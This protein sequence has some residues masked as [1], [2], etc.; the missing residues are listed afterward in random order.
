MSLWS[1]LQSGLRSV[2]ASTLSN[3]D[4]WLVRWLRGDDG[5]GSDSGVTVNAKTVLTYAPVWMGVNKIVGLV[6]QLPLCAYERTDER[7]NVKR[8]DHAGSYVLDY[9]NDLMDASV[10]RETITAHAILQGNGRA[11][12]ERD[13]RN[14]PLELIPLLP[15]RTKTILVNNKKWHVVTDPTTGEISK[16]PGADVL[17]ICGFGFDG[18]QGYSLVEMAKNSIGLGLAAEKHTNRHFKNNAIPSL[19][20]EAPAGVLTK[21]TEAKAFLKDWNDYHQGLTEN[22]KAGLLRGGIKATQLGMSGRDSQWIEQR[23]FQ[24]Q[25]AALWLAIEQ[26]LGD[27]SSVSYNSLEQK[28][29]AFLVNCLMRWNVKWEQQCNRKLLT[30]QQRESRSHYFKF[31]VAALMRATLKERYEVYA[32][33]VQN[34]ILNPNECRALE[35]LPPYE[36]GDEYKNPAITPKQEAPQTPPK[37][38]TNVPPADP[39]PPELPAE[40]KAKPLI[41]SR[42]KEIV[43]VETQRAIDAAMKPN[44]FSAWLDRFYSD[45]G[46]VPRFDA[47]VRDCGG[48]STHTLAH[49]AESKRVLLDLSGKCGADGFAAAVQ[50]ETGK[51]GERV[52]LLTTILSER[53]PL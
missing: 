47:V 4:S 17:H 23:K 20:L 40:D 49:L 19:I 53:K 32:S 24:R 8:P 38:P 42:I 41:R 30:V 48:D 39:I 50:L 16:L 44:Q 11:Y 51:W 22:S 1:R 33:A 9:P 45:D 21:E 15:D 25:E 31:T 2:F 7:H 37:Q 34:T 43:K 52:E 35:D 10:F 18:I 5:D 29:M 26:I 13:G 6:G 3:P 46:F 36:G 27:D 14:N 12:I 28:N